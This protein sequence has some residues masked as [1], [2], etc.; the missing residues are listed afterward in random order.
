MAKRTPEEIIQ[1][2]SDTLAQCD[3]DFIVEIANRVLTRKVK[4]LGDGTLEQED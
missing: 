2:I 3:E 4:V 1:D